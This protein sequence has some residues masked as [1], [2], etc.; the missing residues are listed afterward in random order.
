[1][2]SNSSK[3]PSPI[4]IT[5]LITHVFNNS[6]FLTHT[7]GGRGKVATDGWGGVVVGWRGGGRSRIR[8]G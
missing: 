2:S 7:E 6:L 1:M 3:C 5:A 4:R 8:E